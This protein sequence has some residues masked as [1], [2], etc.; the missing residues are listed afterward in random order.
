MACTMY[1]VL[2]FFRLHAVRTKRG[3]PCIGTPFRSGSATTRYLGPQVLPF[4]GVMEFTKAASYE[5]INAVILESRIGTSVPRLM[6]HDPSGVW[7]ASKC[8]QPLPLLR[9]P[10]PSMSVTSAA[11]L[12]GAPPRGPA[13]WPGA[14]LHLL[15]PRATQVPGCPARSSSC[16][17]G[18]VNQPVLQ[19]CLKGS[20]QDPGQRAI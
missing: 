13:P 5:L 2:V 14:T 10:L 19:A 7:E 20:A 6:T 4:L 9:C 17:P 18:P 3:A 16:P 15:L 1:T 11:G 8:L 12:A